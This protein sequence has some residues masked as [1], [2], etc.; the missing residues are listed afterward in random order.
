M[1][2]IATWNCN[3]AFRTKK[4]R[5]LEYDPDILVIQECENPATTGDWDEFSD[6][7]W[8]GDNDHKG[9]GIFCRNGLTIEST[10]DRASAAR[11]VLPVRIA[12]SFNVLGIWAM[13]DETD[14]KQRYI[15]QVYTALQDYQ[16]FLTSELIVAG[17]FNWNV[18]W[19]ESPAAPLYGD[20]IETVD[21]LH[22]AGLISSY[23]RVTTTKYGNEAAPTFF[24][25]KNRDRSYHTDYLFMPASLVYAVDEFVVGS[26]EEWIDASD[27]MPILV[28]LDA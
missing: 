17:D 21:T 5:L 27:H 8:I 19:D 11:Y 25:H 15:G 2:T 3:M 28:D 1:T 4:Q 18:I 13:N 9:L 20:F 12:D 16:D 23:H 22:S 26:Y 7:R 6:W 10:V 24:M 14:R